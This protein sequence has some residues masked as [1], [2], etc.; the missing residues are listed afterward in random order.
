M[1]PRATWVRAAL[2]LDA[3][4][5]LPSGHSN[6]TAFAANCRRIPRDIPGKLGEQAH[7][8]KYLPEHLFERALALGLIHAFRE[9]VW[10]IPFTEQ[11]S[12]GK[13]WRM[14]LVE[15]VIERDDDVHL[16]SPLP[17]KFEPAFRAKHMQMRHAM[18]KL[19]NRQRM[20]SLIGPVT[21]TEGVEA[22][23]C[24]LPQKR[25]RHDATR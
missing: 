17:G 14:V 3:R 1:M 21:R 8:A 20:H 11:G 16:R 7:A 25:L 23:A 6:L 15:T 22:I 12:T 13:G 10:E 2:R 9:R 19:G 18:L 4:G 24:K 5:R